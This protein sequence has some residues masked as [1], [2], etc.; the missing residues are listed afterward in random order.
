MSSCWFYLQFS[1]LNLWPALRHAFS[2]TKLIHSGRPSYKVHTAGLCWDMIFFPESD[3]HAQKTRRRAHHAVFTDVYLQD[4]CLEIVRTKIENRLWETDLHLLIGEPISETLLTC[5]MKRCE[6]SINCTSV[7]LNLKY[8]KKEMLRGHQIDKRLRSSNGSFYPKW[9]GL[10]WGG[11]PEE[12][13]RKRSSQTPSALERPEGA[14]GT[15]GDNHRHSNV[16]VHSP[17][18]PVINGCF[19]IELCLKCKKA[20]SPLFSI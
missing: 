5:Q 4:K 19:L 16:S 10:L 3:P 7:A 6:R 17:V 12:T 1:P 9:S 8:E 20:I 13:S 11:G 14:T 2:V 15:R 18:W